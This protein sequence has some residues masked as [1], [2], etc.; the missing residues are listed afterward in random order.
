MVWTDFDRK[1]YLHYITLHCLGNKGTKNRGKINFAIIPFIGNWQI[2][3][4]TKGRMQLSNPRSSDNKWRSEGEFWL[5][6]PRPGPILLA[7]STDSL[8]GGKWTFLAPSLKNNSLFIYL[9][10]SVIM[11][12]DYRSSAG[13][14]SGTLASQ[15]GVVTPDCCE[16]VC[17]PV[18]TGLNKPARSQCLVPE[19]TCY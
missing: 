8:S 13:W 6:E 3:A 9:F 17:V 18:P 19:G 7:D 11:L 12:F 1:Q 14:W 2:Y 4:S 15:S 10:F 5:S 16:D